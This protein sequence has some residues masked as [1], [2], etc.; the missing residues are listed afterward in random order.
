MARPMNIALRAI[1]L[2]ALVA[3]APQE[4]PAAPPLDSQGPDKIVPG[5]TVTFEAKGASDVR[6]SRMAALYVPEGSPPTPFLAPGPFKATWEGFL[7]VDLGTDCEFS[8][9]GTGSLVVTI[10]DKPALEAK[11][12]DFTQAK[13]KSVLLKKGRN[14][15]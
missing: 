15:L 6:D 10:N 4:R 13:S 7:S 8:A 3:A 12:P 2:V 9:A 1:T 14:R 11:G 5:L